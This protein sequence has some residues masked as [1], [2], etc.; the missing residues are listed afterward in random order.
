MSL[1]TTANL[2]RELERKYNA[3]KPLDAEAR[4]RLEHYL[5]DITDEELKQSL[6]RHMDG[7]TAVEAGD[8][9]KFDMDPELGTSCSGSQAP[10]PHT[11]WLPLVKPSRRKAT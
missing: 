10:D 4:Q 2:L 6:M 8:L 11:T 3:G 1:S 5:H 9:E 7:W